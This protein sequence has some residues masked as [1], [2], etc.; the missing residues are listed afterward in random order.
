L[1]GAGRLRPRASS[2]VPTRPIAGPEPPPRLRLPFILAEMFDRRRLRSQ[3]VGE[4]ARFRGGGWSHN[5]TAILERFARGG[6]Y[7][8]SRWRMCGSRGGAK[9]AP[10]H[11]KSPPRHDESPG[12]S[13]GQPC[14]S[15]G[16]RAPSP[17]GLPTM[18]QEALSRREAKAAD[19]Q[20]SQGG[21]SARAGLLSALALSAIALPSGSAAMPVLSSW[22]ARRHRRS[23]SVC[24]PCGGRMAH[25]RHTMISRVL[26][27]DCT[28]QRKNT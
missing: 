15:T 22:A 1:E 9:W 17:R 11:L 8:P 4:S 24:T 6:C 14:P 12:S 3:N 20:I 16:A 7:P 19:E 28:I 5:S 21:W 23:R 18:A 25:E 26:I 10:Q 2:L 13:G 27:A